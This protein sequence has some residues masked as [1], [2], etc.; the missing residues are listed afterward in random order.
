M[1]RVGERLTAAHLAGWLFADLLLVLFL[2]SLSAQ[3]FSPVPPPVPSPTPTRTPDAVRTPKPATARLLSKDY[4]ELLIRA[5]FGLMLGT[6]PARAAEERRVVRRMDAV[7]Q[8]RDPQAVLGVNAGPCREHLRRDRQA[9][10][11]IAYGAAPRSSIG[12]ATQVAKRVSDAVIAG[13]PRFAG[14]TAL[15]QWT[16]QGTDQVKMIVFFYES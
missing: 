8:G 10:I 11:I 1:K 6:G 16:E 2:V 9:G 13:H 3:T 15:A 12:L 4:C 14:A 5:D 7:L